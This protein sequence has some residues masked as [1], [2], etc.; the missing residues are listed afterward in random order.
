MAFFKK[1]RLSCTIVTLSC[2]HIYKV[3]NKFVKSSICESFLI[4]CQT[5]DKMDNYNKSTSSEEY[6]N[7]E[8]WGAPKKEGARELSSF[9]K[10]FGP[11]EQQSGTEQFMQGL[12]GKVLLSP[13]RWFHDNVLE[14][15]R[16][17]E[18]E[19]SFYH[20]RYRRVPTI[21]E[22][23]FSDTACKYVKNVKFMVLFINRYITIYD[24][25]IC[26]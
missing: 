10:Y 4:F 20:R 13:V 1:I 2:R 12:I 3:V 21:D 25:C 6:I 26:Y 19:R 18:S 17:P 23:Y 15:T 16:I 7:K 5:M 24:I 8:R 9:E 14:K 11:L 22:C